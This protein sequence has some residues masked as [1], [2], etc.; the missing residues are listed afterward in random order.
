MKSRMGNSIVFDAT[1]PAMKTLAKPVFAILLP[2]W[3]LGK[4]YIFASKAP[5][6]GRC[7]LLSFYALPASSLCEIIGASVLWSVLWLP[8][9]SLAVTHIIDAAVAR[10]SVQGGSERIEIIG[11]SCAKDVCLYQRPWPRQ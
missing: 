7:L 11:R 5:F 6:A 3:L 9:I 8:L 10:Q 4:L 1:I 2:F